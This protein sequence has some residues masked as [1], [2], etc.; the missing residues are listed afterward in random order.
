MTTDP[1]SRTT[2]L[3]RIGVLGCGL[4]GSGIAET[5]ARGG[6]DVL[7][8][9]VSRPAVEAGRRRIEDSLGKAVRRGK[10]TDEERDRA[11]ARLSFSTDLGDL[12]DRELVIEAAV[13]DRALKCALFR[14]VD[15]ILAGTDAILASNT[16]SIPLTDLATATGRPD[17]VI[18]LHFFNPVPVQALVEIIPALTTSTDTLERTRRFAVER[19]GKTAV[20]APDQA[21]FIVNALLLPYLL[22]AVRMVQAGTATPEDIDHGMELGCAHPMGP[23]RLL[24]LIG[25][26]TAKA[27]A[28]SL[29]EEHAE[30]LYAPPPLLRRMVAAG[31]LGRKSGRGFYAY[32]AT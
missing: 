13:E 32:P 21:G 31:H 17:R 22:S 26:D 4:M 24:D 8:T 28:E 20:Q 27:I 7:V 5:V 23:L 14:D 10:L 30:P 3:S 11:L 16:S 9:E 12:A 18:G 2:S 25:L 1:D 15:K 19:L 6:L 29:Y